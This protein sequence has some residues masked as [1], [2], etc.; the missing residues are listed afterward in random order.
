MTQSFLDSLLVNLSTF[1]ECMVQNI[2]E[3]ML[4][5]MNEADQDPESLKQAASAAVLDESHHYLFR[6]LDSEHLQ[7]KYFREKFGM[8]E[9]TERLLGRVLSGST[10]RNKCCY[11]V[12]MI[13]SIQAMLKCDVVHDNVS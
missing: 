10:A 12:S 1:H 13:E 3:S 9:P 4:Q 11:Y 8:I 5:G 7:N 2:H 6:G